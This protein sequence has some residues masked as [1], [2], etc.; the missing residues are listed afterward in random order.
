MDSWTIFQV[1]CDSASMIPRKVHQN[2][3]AKERKPWRD[4]YWARFLE[5][6]SI[7]RRVLVGIVYAWGLFSFDEKQWGFFYHA[8]IF[9]KKKIDWIFRVRTETSYNDGIYREN[10]NL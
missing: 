9:V 2:A 5:A 1:I 4:Y 10:R 7:P 3:E 6:L 8:Y